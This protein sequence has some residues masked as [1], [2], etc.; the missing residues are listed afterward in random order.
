MVS[1]VVTVY[2][3]ESYIEKAL[4]SIIEQTRKPDEIVVIDDA[5]TD[6]TRDIVLKSFAGKVV[7]HRNPTNRERC[8]SRNKG[9]SLSQG[10]YVFFMDYDDLWEEHHVE[11]LLRLWGDAQIVYSFPRRL[12]DATGK[13]IKRSSRSLPQDPCMAVFSGVVGYP[14]AT[15]FRRDYFLEYKD[16]YMVREDWE[17][18][19]RA[20]L[21]GYRI[22]LVDTDTVMI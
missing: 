10:E 11:T 7:Y 13:V 14:S 1:V 9:F 15:A 16:P 21:L 19:V 3:G 4:Q 18:F 17:V 8:Y 2:N 12:I 5:S 22:K 20:C 6:R